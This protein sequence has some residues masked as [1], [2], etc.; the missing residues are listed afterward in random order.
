MKVGLNRIKRLRRLHGIR[1]TRKKK[2]RVTAHLLPIAEN[3]LDRQFVQTALNQVWVAGITYILT[4]EGWL[5]LAALKNLYACE[6]V[7]P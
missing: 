5:Y 7:G 2:F 4:D 1:C 6:I 3:V